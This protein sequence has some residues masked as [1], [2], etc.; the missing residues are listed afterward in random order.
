LGVRYSLVEVRWE[1]DGERGG[2]S[3]E[4]FQVIIEAKDDAAIGA[5]RLEAPIAEREAAVGDGEGRRVGVDSE[6][7]HPAL[8]LPARVGRM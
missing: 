2:G 5:H 6:P 7:V 1:R 4:P 3:R 8:R